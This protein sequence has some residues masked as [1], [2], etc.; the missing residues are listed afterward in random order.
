LLR[1]IELAFASAYAPNSVF[2]N[3]GIEGSVPITP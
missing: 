3:W 2:W 1:P